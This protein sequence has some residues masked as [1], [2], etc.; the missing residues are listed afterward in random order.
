MKFQA[1]TGLISA[2]QVK[3]ADAHAH[4]WIAPPV[5]VTAENRLE[6]NNYDAI[7][8]ELSDS[9]AAGGTTLV[10]CQPG[11]C[12]R[13]ANRL[14]ALAQATG[15]IQSGARPPPLDA[16]YAQGRRQPGRK[17]SARLVRSGRG[18][19]GD[20]QQTGSQGMGPIRQ[21]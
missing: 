6:L 9:R 20:G 7:K 5:G 21:L 12:G 13:D 17:E 15:C 19:C 10:D 8:A 3:L 4:V 16:D 18:V 1:V 14:L 2:D 11:G